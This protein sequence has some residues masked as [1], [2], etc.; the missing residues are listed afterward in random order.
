MCG[1]ENRKE[2][3]VDDQKAADNPLAE[4]QRPAL[5]KTL[6]ARDASGVDH[7]AIRHRLVNLHLF[8]L[9]ISHHPMR[10]RPCHLGIANVPSQ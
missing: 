6:G 10:K 8:D 3:K 2:G 5:D 9:R 1:V 4:A 7:Q